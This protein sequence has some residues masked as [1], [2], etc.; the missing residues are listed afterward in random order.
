MIVEWNNGSLTFILGRF[1]ENF[2][3]TERREPR[4]T[5]VADLEYVVS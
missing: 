3:S 4:Q 1:A 2:I 5:K